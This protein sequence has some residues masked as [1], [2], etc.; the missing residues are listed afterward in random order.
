MSLFV[1]LNRNW[2]KVTFTSIILQ[3]KLTKKSTNLYYAQI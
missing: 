1:N 3:G 2:D